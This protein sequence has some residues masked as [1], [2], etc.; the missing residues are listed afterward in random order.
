MAS[1]RG[2]GEEREDQER[3]AQR[4]GKN[5]H[6][7][8]ERRE[9]KETRRVKTEGTIFSLPHDEWRGRCPERRHC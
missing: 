6:M 3:E 4:Q 8:T 2:G 1:E 5:P 7:Y 9:E